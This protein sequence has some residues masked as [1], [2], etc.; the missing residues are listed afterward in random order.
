V[1]S[2]VQEACEQAVSTTDSQ[3]N[4]P[5]RGKTYKEFHKIYQGLYQD[6]RKRYAELD[7]L[8]KSAE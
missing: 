1:Y 7:K 6:L 8:L 4:D 2:S 5:E 3:Q